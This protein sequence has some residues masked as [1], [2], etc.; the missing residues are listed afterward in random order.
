MGERHACVDCGEK[1]KRAGEF[2][3][4]RNC[5]GPVCAACLEDRPFLKSYG[6]CKLCPKP[7]EPPD[8]G[9]LQV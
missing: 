3:L 8:A 7:W 2:A 6:M 4:C 5:G 1:E 9:D